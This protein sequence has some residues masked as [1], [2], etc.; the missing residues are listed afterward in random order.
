MDQ[1]RLSCRVIELLSV[2]GGFGLVDWLDLLVGV[3]YI[4][5]VRMVRA[6]VERGVY[7]TVDSFF[8]GEG[9][10]LIPFCPVHWDASRMNKHD[11][12]MD[13]VDDVHALEILRRVVTL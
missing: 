2:G 1:C 5:C 10:D 4:E 11:E 7:M 9:G 8:V 13:C 12:C 6:L 3:V